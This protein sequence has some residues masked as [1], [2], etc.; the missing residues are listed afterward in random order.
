MKDGWNKKCMVLAIYA[1][2]VII[3]S[4]VAFFFLSKLQNIGG[5]IGS[6]YDI[7]ETVVW[8]FIFAYLMNPLLV[9]LE[10][11]VLRFK[12]DSRKKFLLKRTLSMI[13]TYLA[14]LGLVLAIFLIIIPEII[15]SLYSI[16]GLI[17]NFQSY[18]KHFN[19]WLEKIFSTKN[20]WGMQ[21]RAIVQKEMNTLTGSLVEKLSVTKTAEKVAIGTYNTLYVFF[22]GMVIS[23]YMLASKEKLSAQIKK[24][25]FAFFRKTKVDSILKFSKFT[26]ETV[27]NYLTGKLLDAAMVGVITF[28][29]LTVFGFHYTAL[30]AFV[31]GASN[32]IPFFGPFIGAIPSAFLLLLVDPMEAVWFVLIILIIQQ[33]DGNFLEPAIL[34]KTVGISS[35]WIVVSILIAGGLFGVVGLILGVPAFTVLYALFRQF[36]NMRL[37][38]KNLPVGSEEYAGYRH[39]APPEEMELFAL[40]APPSKKHK[41]MLYRFVHAIT[42]EEDS[43]DKSVNPVSDD[44]SNEK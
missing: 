21:F 22:V 33:I 44:K 15:S 29:V 3:F 10:K 7:F 43:D 14:F 40:A 26:H 31:V 4:I 16:D 8:G 41:N 37:K 12:V 18:W 30:I 28:A 19:D 11:K 1:F 32:I 39:D 36:V 5:W 23:V 2:M 42:K 24:T 34:G 17:T 20:N 27:G 35:F 13:I 9:L 38:A 25:M 6:L